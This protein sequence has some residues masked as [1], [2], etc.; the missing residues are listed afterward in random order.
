MRKV[1]FIFGV[2]NDSDIDW[3]ARAGSRR[4]ISKQE[5]L[6]HEGVPIDAVVLLLQGRMGVNVS[7]AGEIAQIAAGDLICGVLLGGFVAPPATGDPEGGC[8]VLFLGKQL[9][10]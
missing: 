9:P 7:G 8:V 3:M 4:T 10:L 6:I 5:V 1:L 2:L